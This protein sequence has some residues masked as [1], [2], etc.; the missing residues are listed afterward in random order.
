M[1][2]NSFR[3][4]SFMQNCAAIPQYR[5]PFAALLQPPSVPNT[6]TLEHFFLKKAIFCARC[7]FIFAKIGMEKLH[8]SSHCR[9]KLCNGGREK[10]P[11]GRLLMHS[12]AYK[13][14]AFRIEYG[15]P[16]M[17]GG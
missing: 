14:K 5:S 11:F 7:L 15:F 1:A 12:A 16:F 8:F 2:K 6:K 17:L 4:E 9:Q 3:V 10:K 13:G